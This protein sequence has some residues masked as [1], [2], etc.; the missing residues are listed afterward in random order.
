MPERASLHDFF[1]AEG[2]RLLTLYKINQY[3]RSVTCPFAKCENAISDISL[4]LFLES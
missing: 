3:N 1:N 4:K 2:T